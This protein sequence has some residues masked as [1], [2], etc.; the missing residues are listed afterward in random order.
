MG[1]P[2]LKNGVLEVGG[3]SGFLGWFRLGEVGDE[4]P[5]RVNSAERGSD[6]YV[7]VILDAL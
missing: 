7:L 3:V 5:G 6:A 4:G 2:W 1:T